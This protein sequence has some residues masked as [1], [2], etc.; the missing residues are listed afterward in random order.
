MSS[1][2]VVRTSGRQY[3]VSE[4]SEFEV[5]QIE[6]NVGDTVELDD[7]LLVTGDGTTTVGTPTVSGAKVTASIVQQKRGPK[8]TIFK[9][10]RRQGKQLNKGHRQDL[11]RLRVQSISVQ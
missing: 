6:G 3:F 4:G 1:M 8:V 2:V 9:K 7:V 10:I 11:T 5:N